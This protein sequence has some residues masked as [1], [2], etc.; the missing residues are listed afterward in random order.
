M[1]RTLWRSTD[2][3]KGSMSGLYSAI[4]AMIAAMLWGIFPPATMRPKDTFGG[5]FLSYLLL[6]FLKVLLDDA[7]HFHDKKKHAK[8]W[9]HGLGLNIV[10]NIF[11]L[12]A[13]RSSTV[14]RP[15]AVLCAL[16]AQVI[17]VVWLARNYLHAAA[18]SP[19]DIRRHEAWVYINC[20][21]IVALAIL[22]THFDRAPREVPLVLVTSLFVLTGFDFLYFGTLQR[23]RD[24]L[25]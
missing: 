19:D 25:D 21:N 13:I 16:L 17:G 15:S 18:G 24:A 12:N 9:A 23:V 20:F 7:A 6:L 1:A 10:W 11:V 8:N 5:L 4:V 3:S 14:D 2:G 22:G